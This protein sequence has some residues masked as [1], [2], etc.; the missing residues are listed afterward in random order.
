MYINKQKIHK[1]HM[2]EC[3]NISLHE[4]IY[5]LKKK[6]KIP[7]V[8]LCLQQHAAS[9]SSMLPWQQLHC[10]LPLCVLYFC[11]HPSTLSKEKSVI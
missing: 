11:F 5:T 6:K 1:I 10:S 9:V 7:E 4:K 2:T 8:N 3:F